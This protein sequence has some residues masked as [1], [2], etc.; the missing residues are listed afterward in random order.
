MTRAAV[1]AVHGEGQRVVGV[2][3]AVGVEQAGGVEGEG[4]I[5]DDGA[6]T[7]I[8]LARGGDADVIGVDLPTL[9]GERLSR[10]GDAARWCRRR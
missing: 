6:A 9:V 3:F 1:V 10:A 4:V 8:K 2:G 7:V 5:G